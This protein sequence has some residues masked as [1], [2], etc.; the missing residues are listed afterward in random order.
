MLSPRYFAVEKSMRF[1][2]KRTALMRYGARHTLLNQP[3][4]GFTAPNPTLHPSA[5]GLPRL[6]THLQHVHPGVA[7]LRP[8]TIGTLP[9]FQNCYHLC[10]HQQIPGHSV[11]DL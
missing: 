9:I 3:I 6:S 7:R 4:Q 10:L 2:F 8:D 11:R 5:V 1:L